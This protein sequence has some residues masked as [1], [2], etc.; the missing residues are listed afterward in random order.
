MKFDAA[1]AIDLLKVSASLSDAEKM[2][3]SHDIKSA[4]FGFQLMIEEY[5]LILNSE[6]D[7]K[8]AEKLL[9]LQKHHQ[10]LDQLAKHLALMLK[11][12]VEG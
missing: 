1:K 2:R 11:S 5:R 8:H 4:V 10:I 12:G 6:E 7:Q 9:Q 3:L